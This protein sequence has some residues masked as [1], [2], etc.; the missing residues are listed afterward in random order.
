VHAAA[1]T[2][3]DGHRKDAAADNARLRAHE[4]SMRFIAFSNHLHER[5]RVLTIL[6]R[7]L[8]SDRLS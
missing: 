6:H 5:D 4:V 3:C 2:E 1:R 7:K 8:S